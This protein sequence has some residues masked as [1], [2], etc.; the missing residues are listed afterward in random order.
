MRTRLVHSLITVALTV[1][2]GGLVAAT[3]V[4]YAPGFGVDERELDARLSQESVRQIRTETGEASGPVREGILSYYLRY[5]ARA[6]TGDLG[7]SASFQRPI[8]ALIA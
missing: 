4:R 1:L 5:L 8:V 6:A 7:V 3:L 2:L